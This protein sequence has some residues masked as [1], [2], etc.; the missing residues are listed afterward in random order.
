MEAGAQHL[1]ADKR[2]K[3]KLWMT[4]SILA[5]MEKRRIQK[6]NRMEYKRLQ[7]IIKNE[8]KTAKH[9]WM[10]EQSQEMEELVSKNEMLN[11][12]K[13]IKEMTGLHKKWIPS[14]IVDD[15]NR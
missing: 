14:T 10:L 6:N 15:A 5:L 4:D 1:K 3:K 8:I 7:S 12:H 11:L 13:K 2:I 9:T